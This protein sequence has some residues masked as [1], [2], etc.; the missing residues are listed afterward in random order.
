M[1]VPIL[2][3]LYIALSGLNKTSGSEGGMIVTSDEQLATQARKFAGIDKGLTA[4]VWSK[5]SASSVYQDPSY[6]RFDTI[7]FN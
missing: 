3:S 2:I 1:L 6:E 7:G 5:F 4:L